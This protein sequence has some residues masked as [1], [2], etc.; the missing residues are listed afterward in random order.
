MQTKKLSTGFLSS[1]QDAHTPESS[2]TGNIHGM[3]VAHL[4]GHGAKELCEIGDKL[5]KILPK[6]MAFI[7]IRSYEPP[8]KVRNSLTL[9][10][11]GSR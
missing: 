10:Q 11:S 3:P 1:L 7:G 8:E 2:D 6:N 5:P 9:F 4:L